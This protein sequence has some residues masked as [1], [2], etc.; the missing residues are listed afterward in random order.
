MR[1]SGHGL[2]IDSLVRV[3]G[4]VFWFGPLSAISLSFV[5][6]Y[7]RVGNKDAAKAQVVKNK[8]LREA[9]ARV[10]SRS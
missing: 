10:E 2:G 6:L 3:Y 8:R 1:I 9:V 7:S 5:E 4:L